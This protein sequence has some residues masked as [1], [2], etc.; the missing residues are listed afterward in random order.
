LKQLA[1]LGGTACR[2]VAR[3]GGP[4]CLPHRVYFKCAGQKPRAPKIC[5][6]IECIVNPLLSP[7]TGGLDEFVPLTSKIRRTGGWRA[8]TIHL[9]GFALLSG[10]DLTEKETEPGER[11]DRLDS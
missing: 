9:S 3:A 6:Y 7:L 5:I 4:V 8:E 11:R 2:R 1:K 10:Y